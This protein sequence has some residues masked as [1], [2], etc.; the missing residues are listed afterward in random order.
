[1]EHLG[2][3]DEIIDVLCPST[4]GFVRYRVK[5]RWNFYFLIELFGQRARMVNPIVFRVDLVSATFTEL[6]L[7]QFWNALRWHSEIGATNHEEMGK[8]IPSLEG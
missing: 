6:S 7:D 4:I 8:N 1:M 5:A 2:L 3:H